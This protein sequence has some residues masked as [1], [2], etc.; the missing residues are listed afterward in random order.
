MRKC[1]WL[2]IVTLLLTVLS[3]PVMAADDIVTANSTGYNDVP[4]SNGYNGFCLDK[5]LDI[6]YKED[7][8]VVSE[9]SEATNNGSGESISQYLKIL[10][11]DFFDTVFEKKDG[12]Y[13]EK[14]RQ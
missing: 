13:K 9:A 6:A 3:L 14:M 7:G 11:V 8:F 1:A 4:F 12:E 10:F 5:W 2:V